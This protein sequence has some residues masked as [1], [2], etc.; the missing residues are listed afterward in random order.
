MPTTAIGRPTQVMNIINQHMQAEYQNDV[1]L[2]ME[3][4]DPRPRY[5]LTGRNRSTIVLDDTAGVRAMYTATK[6]DADLIVQREACRLVSDW[7]LFG[8]SN[9]LYRHKGAL[10]GVDRSGVEYNVPLVAFLPVID[11]L[12]L[13]EFVYWGR[14]AAEAIKRSMRGEDTP[15]PP[16]PYS[17]IRDLHDEL[18]GRLKAHEPQ[19]LRELFANDAY[20]VT[21]D[22]DDPEAGLLI[23]EGIDAIVAHH[24]RHLASAEFVDV[25]I[26]SFVASDWYVFAEHRWDLVDGNGERTERRV[27]GIYTIDDTGK[28]GSYIGYGA[29]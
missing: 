5:V 15:P 12:L 1:D 14:T 4:V 19:R 2:I 13:G 3:T 10:D 29:N 21:R 28:L 27:A 9:A 7:Y 17:P 24:E 16:N 11:E 20:F 25:T 22:Y 6:S 8:E 26:T 18:V 23:A